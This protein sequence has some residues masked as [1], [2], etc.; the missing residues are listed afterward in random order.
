[1]LYIPIWY[2]SSNLG[3]FHRYTKVSGFTFQSGTIQAVRR[4]NDHDAE[5]PLH[6]N[7]V[8]FKPASELLACLSP[9]FTF[10]SGT[11]QA[12]FICTAL[13]QSSLY[14]PIWYNSSAGDYGFYCI[15]YCFT[16]QSGTIQAGL[17]PAFSI[18]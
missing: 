7:L 12:C 17:C 18:K 15:Y 16:F 3:A 4:G 10:Q 9:S 6:S 2:N 5:E 1:M 8:Q 13:Q 14:I 11:I